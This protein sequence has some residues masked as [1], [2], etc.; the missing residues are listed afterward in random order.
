[1]IAS[2]KSC[3]YGATSSVRS[4]ERVGRLIRT[5]ARLAL[6]IPICQIV[7]DVFACEGA[8]TVQ[9]ALDCLA[10]IVDAVFGAGTLALDKL[11]FGPSLTILGVEVRLCKEFTELQPSK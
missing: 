7:D 4:W 9:H 6:K 10:R 2:H 3:M 5:V 11:A 1:M 8:E